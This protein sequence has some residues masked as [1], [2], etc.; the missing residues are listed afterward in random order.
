MR[1]EL[2]EFGDLVAQSGQDLDVELF[3]RFCGVFELDDFHG[4]RGDVVVE[5]A[6]CDSVVGEQLENLQQALA[7]DLH[8]LFVVWVVLQEGRKAHHASIWV[9]NEYLCA[10]KSSYLGSACPIPWQ[11]SAAG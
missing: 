1:V 2:V 10:G 7:A 4:A 3:V 9:M 5:H 6:Y 8:D 11:T